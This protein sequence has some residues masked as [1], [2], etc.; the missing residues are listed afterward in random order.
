M[1][2]ICGLDSDRHFPL[3]HVALG[4][5]IG[6]LVPTL[7]FAQQ[8]VAE[9]PKNVA[10][11][12]C[13]FTQFKDTAPIYKNLRTV[14][15]SIEFPADLKEALDC[16]DH[17]EECAKRDADP[18]ID[19]ERYVR[20][21]VNRLKTLTNGYPQAL[22]PESLKNHFRSMVLETF[23]SVLPRTSTCTEP[24]PTFL[25]PHWPDHA[26]SSTID[27]PDV[28]NLTVT[29]TLI[30]TTNPH[31]L[32]LSTTAFRKDFSNYDLSVPRS[33]A[34]PIDL[35]DQQISSILEAYLR[36]IKQR[37]GPGTA[38]LPEKYYGDNILVLPKPPT[39]VDTK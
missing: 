37:T 34:I 29:I 15:V 11:A 6:L 19:I 27:S 8:P 30:I 3:L 16:H 21:K 28:L 7:A 13:E 17:E 9:S 38:R 12:A 14:N 36:T 39:N 5:F 31:V 10:A 26:Y 22:Y 24:E 23:N 32:F 20:D 35:P 18:H 33:T 1:N 2:F 4:A 25:H